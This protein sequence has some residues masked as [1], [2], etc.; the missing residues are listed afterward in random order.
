MCLICTCY[1]G[2]M[3][4]RAILNGKAHP[5][6]KATEQREDMYCTTEMKM[7]LQQGVCVS[8]LHRSFIQSGHSALR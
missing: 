7:R 2:A 4:Y 6:L 8:V 5:L 1:Y 3:R